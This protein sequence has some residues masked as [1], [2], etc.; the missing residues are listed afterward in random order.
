MTDNIQS[1]RLA[2]RKSLY[3]RIHFWAALIATPFALLA[4]LTGML[5]VFTPQIETV[6]YGHLDHVTP[7]G[8][9]LSLDAAVAASEQAAPKG[10]V[11]QNVVPPF[12]AID[13]VQVTFAPPGVQVDEHAG[14]NMPGMKPPVAKPAFVAPAQ[15]VVVYVNPY[16][17]IVLGTLASS[18]RFN[19]WARKLH[20]RLLQTDGWRWMIELA[21]SWLMVMLV[22]G[23]ILWWPRGVQSGLPKK[24]AT[25]RNGWRQW[26]AF[27][28]VALG[29]VSFV[30]LA[31]GL[32][33]S[34]QAGGRIRSLRDISGQANPPVP[35]SL[36]SREDVHGG[37]L[38]WQGAWQAARSNAPAI[39][40]QLTAPASQQDVW[41][42]TMADRSQPLKRFD[43]QFDA[44][45]GKPLYYAGWD[46]QT[47]F[48]KAT[49]IGIP[50]HRGE[51]GWWNQALLFVFGASVLF[52]LVSGWIMFFK[53]RAPGTL[54]L[55]KLLPGAWTS[56]S[57]LAWLVAAAM[58]ALMPLLLISGAVLALLELCLAQASRRQSVAR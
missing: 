48:G 16:D 10:W 8:A 47:A 21:A 18:Q 29:L 9:M 42:V 24:G 49:A 51:F 17:G 23:V 6:L 34:Q 33:W 50:F 14:H 37:P 53:R 54:G 52:S 5:Y 35:R 32:T 27:L 22:T 26:H 25:G 15:A 12:Q 1:R 2:R 19:N 56:P 46:E 41:R 43:L 55:P 30:I 3:W 31:T 36:H 11:V 20:S 39:A 44:Y 28:G 7:H 58:C 38:D 40:L 4:A 45:S 57:P 13:S